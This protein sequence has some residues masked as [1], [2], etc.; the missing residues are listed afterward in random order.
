MGGAIAQAMAAIS[1][2]WV[3]REPQTGPRKKLRPTVTADPGRTGAPHKPLRQDP[4]PAQVKRS[5]QLK[6][7]RANEVLP[8]PNTPHPVPFAPNLTPKQ[9]EALEQRVAMRTASSDDV[10]RLDWDRRFNNRRDRG[11]KRFFSAERS[12]VLESQPTD[13]PW[14]PEQQQDLRQRKRPVGPD[15]NAIEGHHVYNAADYPH[16]AADP[17]NIAAASS[18]EHLYKWHGGNWQNDTHGAPLNPSYKEKG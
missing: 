4:A 9:R 5:L 6:D 8:T 11:V 17:N 12:K 13:Y 16:K 1:E 10:Y 18:S 2:P 14:T 3:D 7:Q 15:G